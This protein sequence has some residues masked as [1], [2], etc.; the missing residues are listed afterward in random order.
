MISS[1]FKSVGLG[2]AVGNARD[3]VKAVAKEIT[4]D[5]KQDGVANALYKH[6]LSS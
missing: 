6:L 2:I 3:E 4:L 5:S 1:Y